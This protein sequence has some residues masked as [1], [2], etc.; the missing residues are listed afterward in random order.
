[1]VTFPNSL[2]SHITD[3]LRKDYRELFSNWHQFLAHLQK[4]DVL[5]A[6]SM[7]PLV[8]G[9]D[10]KRA[11]NAK[12][13]KWLVRALDVCLE[14]QFRHPGVDDKEPAIQEVMNKATELG[15]GYK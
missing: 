15:I 4:K 10:L 5:N 6:D 7:K 11:L 1:M 13:G 2:R 12:P 9:E 8:D 3:N 14:W